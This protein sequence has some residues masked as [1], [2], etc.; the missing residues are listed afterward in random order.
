MFFSKL[1]IAWLAATTTIKVTTAS[2]F[3]HEDHHLSN[4]DLR[5]LNSSLAFPPHGPITCSDPSPDLNEANLRD[6]ASALVVMQSEVPWY[7]KARTFSRIPRPVDQEVPLYFQDKTC[8]IVMSTTILRAS[9]T[10][11]LSEVHN[12]AIE[13]VKECV[14]ERKP[15]YKFGG[16]ASIGHNKGFYFKVRGNEKDPKNFTDKDGEGD[17]DGLTLTKSTSADKAAARSIAEDLMLGM[18]SSAKPFASAVA[19]ASSCPAAT[20]VPAMA[21]GIKGPRPESEAL[22]TA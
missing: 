6:C 11:A 10:Y 17:G 15:G 20:P 16:F 2:P 13:I 22:L 9:D 19:A 8:M 7:N 3:N 5:D 14:K 1:T 18:I 4:Y 12:T 21:Q